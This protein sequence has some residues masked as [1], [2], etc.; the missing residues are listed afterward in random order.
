MPTKHLMGGVRRVD[1]F[2]S[3]N[4]E[5]WR[6]VAPTVR[7]PLGADNYAKVIIWRDVEPRRKKELKHG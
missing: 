6:E 1:G 3:F 7:L 2:S 5:I 4:Q